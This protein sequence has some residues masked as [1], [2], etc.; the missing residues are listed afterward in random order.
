[1]KLTKINRIYQN[2]ES[3]LSPD[4][5]TIIYGPRRVGKT[6][7]VESSI[8]FGQPQNLNVYGEDVD[9]Q[10]IFSSQSIE[11]IKNFIGGSQIVFIDEAQS[12]PNIGLN[13]KIIVDKIKVK[14]VATGSSSFELAGQTGE[15][16]VGRK[17]ELHLYPVS[18][19]ELV[20]FNG[21]NWLNVSHNL[22]NLLIFGGYPQILTTDSLEAKQKVITELASSYLFKDILSLDKIKNSLTLNNL[23]KMLALQL[24]SEVSLNEL[25]TS[26]GI[27]GKTVARYLDLLEKAF[28]I[29]RLTGFSGNLR[30]EISK[31]HKYYFYDLGIRNAVIKNFN[32]LNLR[33]DVGALWENSC[34]VER[35]KYLS[36]TNKS[37]NSYFWRSW[38]GQEIDLVEESGGKL[39]T[40]EFK[41]S[42]KKTPRIPKSFATAYPNHTYKV[43]TP[44][45]ILEFLASPK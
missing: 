31:K 26:L 42:S 33:S 25:A 15:P 40:F 3:M 35:K 1:M 7:L 10:A 23:L 43:I 29:F 34:I 21:F 2:L 4:R 8:N 17:T 36:Y 16:L 19:Y 37:V 22:E 32:P 38:E 24:G 45:N 41:F 27:D 30:K 9:T 12:V 39:N 20:K 11:K 13:L 5:V 14:T 28:V 6:T 44:D 18:I